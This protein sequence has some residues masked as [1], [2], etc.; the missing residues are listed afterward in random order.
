MVREEVERRIPRRLS[1]RVVQDLTKSR[2]QNMRSMRCQQLVES[3]TGPI[4][5]RGE[6]R[7]DLW[8]LI[9]QQMSDDRKNYFD[10][11]LITLLPARS[12]KLA[13]KKIIEKR[14]SLVTREGPLQLL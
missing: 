7:C 6:G 14:V 10:S 13:T 8:L 3:I 12:T 4:N 11:N 5:G 1:E 2:C 9:F